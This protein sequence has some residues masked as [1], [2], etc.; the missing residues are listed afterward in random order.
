MTGPVKP[1]FSHALSGAG[2]PFHGYRRGSGLSAKAKPHAIGG[3]R[4]E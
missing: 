4:R 1:E 3:E 2:T